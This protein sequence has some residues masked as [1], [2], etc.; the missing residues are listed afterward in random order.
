MKRSI[1]FSVAA[2]PMWCT[3]AW[4][5]YRVGNKHHRQDRNPAPDRPGSDILYVDCI[6]VVTR[7]RPNSCNMARSHRVHRAAA[8]DPKLQPGLGSFLRI[9]IGRNARL[10]VLPPLRDQA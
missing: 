4:F 2:L 8:D 7:R 6:I 5:D 1:F 9:A 10:V 3:T